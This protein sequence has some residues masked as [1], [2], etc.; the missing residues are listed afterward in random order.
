VGWQGLA[1]LNRAG[2]GQ[3]YTP[4]AYGHSF[5]GSKSGS[6]RLKGDSVDALS[7][8]NATWDLGPKE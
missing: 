3:V 7:G 5:A 8:A 6:A 1:Y 4:A 2:Q